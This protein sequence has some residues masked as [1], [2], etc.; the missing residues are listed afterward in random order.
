MV[1]TSETGAA[2][3]EKSMEVLPQI[4]NTATI[5][6]NSTFWCL[7]VEHKTLTQKDTCTPCSLR[8]YLQQSSQ[9][10]KLSVH[11]WMNG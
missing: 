4:K 8:H 5:C 6:R 3:M 2:T 10:H 11:Q 1:G 7:S 9:G